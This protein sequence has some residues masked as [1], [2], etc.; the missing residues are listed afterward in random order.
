[1]EPAYDDLVSVLNV[2]PEKDVHV[3]ICKC[4]KI[5]CKVI[6]KYKKQIIKFEATDVNF[7]RNVSVLYRGGITSKRKYISI[8]SSLIMAKMTSS[9]VKS[10]IHFMQDVGIP[11]LLTYHRL[12]K[13]M[14]TIHI[15]R[16]HDVREELCG[17][18][19]EQDKV[20]GKYI[21]LLQLLLRLA[22]F[23]LLADQQRED[24]LKWFGERE[25]SFKVVI[26]GDE[27]PFGKDDQSLSWLV[28]FVNYGRRIS[29]PKE[30]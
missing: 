12:V 9:N 8:R 26:G 29:S 3:S 27:A 21:D 10:H 11:K 28:I 16:L 19:A 6:P 22:Q 30:N 18:M 7:V 14:E 15:G 24:K 20:D 1:M 17:G 25:G 23:Y 4:H 5:K 2:I 13:K